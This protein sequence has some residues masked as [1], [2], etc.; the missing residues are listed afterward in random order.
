[1]ARKRKYKK[2]EQPKPAG[3]ILSE[4]QEKKLQK[5]M[6]DMLDVAS[7]VVEE[8]ENMEIDFDV[9]PIQDQE[10]GKMVEQLNSLSS[11]LEQVNQITQ[12][13]ESSPFLDDIFKGDQWKKIIK[14]IPTMPTDPEEDKDND[15]SE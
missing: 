7:S 8:Y 6:T 4:K 1:M 5:I 11:S 14:N 12:I 3:S 13:H 2:K 9:P 10:T 15:A